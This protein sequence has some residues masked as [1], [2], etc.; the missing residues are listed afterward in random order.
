MGRA[1][2][3]AGDYGYDLAHQDVPA[4]TSRRDA[5][6]GDP[7]PTSGQEDTAGDYGYD[8]AHDF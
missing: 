1:Q 8:E 5:G 4:A 6:S 3:P 2:E 7:V